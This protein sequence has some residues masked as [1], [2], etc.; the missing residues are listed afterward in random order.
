MNS[1]TTSSS[2]ATKAIKSFLIGRHADFSMQGGHIP[3][4]VLFRQH[5]IDTGLFFLQFWWSPLHIF[6]EILIMIT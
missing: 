1:K 5:V 4:E 6:N 2:Y 3:K